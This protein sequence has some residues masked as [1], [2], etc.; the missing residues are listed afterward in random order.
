MAE[1]QIEPVARGL[2]NQTFLVRV[3]GGQLVLQ[4]LN[5]IFDAR[6]HRNIHAVT[7]RLARAG[8]ATPRL[9]ATGSGQLWAESDEGVWRLMTHMAGACF[10]ALES[11]AQAR[12]AGALVAR[13]HAALDDL[14]HRFV[15]LRSGVHDTPRHLATLRQALVDHP[16]HRLHPEVAALAADLLASIGE[17]EP[18]PPLAARVCHGDLKVSNVMFGG[19]QPGA[20]DHAVCL[21]DLDTV[22]PLPLAYELGDAW[23]S[24]CNP[25]REDEANPAFDLGLFEAAWQG[26]RDARDA[27]LDDTTRRALLGGVEWITAELTARFAADALRECYFGFDRLRYPAAGEHNLARARGQWSLHRSTRATRAARAAILGVAG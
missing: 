15:A 25:S 11:P 10:D 22:G 27:P 8:V 4:R 3:D 18:L 13:F 14:P 19:E 20:R 2:I 21:I 17:L 26:Y 6:I 12:S 9:L 23:R 24:W 1:A 7:E 5:P 16:S